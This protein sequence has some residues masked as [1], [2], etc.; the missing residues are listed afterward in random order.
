MVHPSARTLAIIGLIVG[1]L[2]PIAGGVALARAAGPRPRPRRRPTP[3]PPPSTADDPGPGPE[4]RGPAPPGRGL[5]RAGQQAREARKSRELSAVISLFNA[6]QA[7]D[8]SRIR[9]LIR[10]GTIAERLDDP[11]IRVQ[12]RNYLNQLNFVATLSGRRLVADELLKDL[13][14]DPAKACWE[15]CAPTFVREVRATQNHDVARELQAWIGATDPWAFTATAP[16]VRATAGARSGRC[17]RRGSR[18]G[19]RAGR[20]TARSAPRPAGPALPRR[21]RRGRRGRAPG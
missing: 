15:R 13:F 4:P 12:L 20:G 6:H 3:S 21:G 11:E 2:G 9:R 17:R 18:C 14:H 1:V 16:T 19:R 7:E 10:D 5:S 8:A